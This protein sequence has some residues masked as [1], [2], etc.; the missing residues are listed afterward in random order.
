M[1]LRG[2]FYKLLDEPCFFAIEKMLGAGKHM[3]FEKL[4]DL[5]IW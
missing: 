3:G 1:R 4:K 2:N 5:P